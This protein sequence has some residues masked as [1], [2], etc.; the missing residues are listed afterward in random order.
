MK[1]A[2][3]SVLDRPWGQTLGTLGTR[4]LTAQVTLKTDDGK[5]YAIAFA[6]G[7]VVGAA[8]PLANDSI[9]RV[10]LTNHFIS[11]PQVSELTRRIAAENRDELEIVA[12]VAKLMPDQISVLRR[13]L[14]IQRAARTFSIDRGTFE[15]HDEVTLPMQPGFGVSLATVI[16]HGVRMNL[17]EQRLAE[18][19][20]ELGS[21]Y[22]LR[23]TTR[24]DDIA[25]LGVDGDIR[26]IVAALRVG[27]T[28]AEL[29][30]TYREI[31]PRT[32]HAMLY[33]LVC[34]N[35][36]EATGGQPVDRTAPSAPRTSTGPVNHRVTTVCSEVP[37]VA[38]KVTATVVPRTVSPNLVPRTTTKPGVVP[39]RVPTDNDFAVRAQGSSPLPVTVSRTTS[40]FDEPT[41]TPRSTPAITRAITAPRTVTERE[42][43]AREIEVLIATRIAKL[44]QGADYFAMLGVPFEAPIEAVR[45]AFVETSRKLHPD[46]LAQVNLT[47]ETKQA[48]RVLAQVNAAFHV[49]NDP[50]KRRDYVDAVRRGEPTP[51]APRARTGDLDS[52]ELAAESFEKGKSA[53]ERDDISRAV[54]EL[55]RAHQLSPS[56]HEYSMMFAWAQFCA[57]PDK[58]KAYADTRKVLQSVIHRVDNPV[59]ARFYLGR[60]ERM[61]GHDREA[62]SHFELVLLEQPGHK[63]AQSEIRV[64]QSRL[65]KGT[66][67][68]R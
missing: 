55:G 62:M 25:E 56:N 47:N 11:A 19:L 15:I 61:L 48:Q 6:D 44:E 52:N 10:A 5:L 46:S 31:E 64:L 35:A 33:A 18:D 21:R 43:A 50:Q 65:A 36:C 53:L 66:K 54:E 29:E 22:R 41:F 23:T 17:S 57:A 60:V 67:P 1:V 16:F 30:A 13:R 3:G 39:P 14:V 4:K 42:R 28:R 68:K 63:E 7:L 49:L 40:G 45:A 38:R 2:A 58:T 20:R 9:A 51:V 59:A 26:E 8:S 34:T 12:D 32:L 24:D 27:T 37:L